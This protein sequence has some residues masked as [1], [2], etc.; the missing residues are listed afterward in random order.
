[1]TLPGFD[2]DDCGGYWWLVNREHTSDGNTTSTVDQVMD[3]ICSGEK[4]LGCCSCLKVQYWYD[5]QFYLLKKMSARVIAAEVESKD[6]VVVFRCEM[7]WV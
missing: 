1:M 7:N 2:F 3:E 6:W 5:A 4:S